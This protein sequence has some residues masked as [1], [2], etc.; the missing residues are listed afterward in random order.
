MVAHDQPP[1][2]EQVEGLPVWT[3]WSIRAFWRD[4]SAQPATRIQFRP[5]GPRFNGRVYVL[6]SR[7]T[8]SAAE[9]TADALVGSGVAT[10]IGEP[11]AGQMLSQMPFDLPGG[12]QLF[13]PIANYV[14]W[15]SGVIEGR[16]VTPRIPVA[17]A[18]A[19]S[20]ALAELDR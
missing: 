12:L 14:S 4:V 13:A 17:A 2:R 1:V 16:G 10:L 9:M 6:T 5:E 19:L 18:D 3:G 11:T 15:H 8:A 20:A 7:Q